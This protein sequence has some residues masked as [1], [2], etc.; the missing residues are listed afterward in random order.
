MQKIRKSDLNINNDDHNDVVSTVRTMALNRPSLSTANLDLK[1][2][3][4]KQKVKT[5]KDSID[6][7]AN[8]TTPSGLKWTEFLEVCTVHFRMT[9]C[10][11]A[12]DTP[13]M[14]QVELMRLEILEMDTL[15]S[16]WESFCIQSCSGSGK[17]KS[18]CKSNVHNI[19]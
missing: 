16:V 6:I 8:A 2:L 5:Y 11:Q 15:Q 7:K 12:D 17:T 4:E 10:L 9:F 3:E 19:L 18:F 14:Q 1:S 13:F